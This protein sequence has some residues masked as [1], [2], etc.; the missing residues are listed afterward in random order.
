MKV[1]ALQLGYYEHCRR[2]AGDVFEMDDAF[3]EGGKCPSWVKP[4][5]EEEEPAPK[6][7][8]KERG[9]KQVPLAKAHLADAA[10]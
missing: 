10:D 9:F 3:F 4:L 8:K 2:R 5:K 6:P 7:A 1:E